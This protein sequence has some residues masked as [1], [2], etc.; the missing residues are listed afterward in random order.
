MSYGTIDDLCFYEVVGCPIILP[1]RSILGYVEGIKR[2]RGGCELWLLRTE[3][4]REIQ[5]PI[6]EQLIVE[7]NPY[8]SVLIDPP[9]YLLDMYREGRHPENICDI[10]EREVASYRKKAA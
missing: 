6:Y 5:F 3:D 8:E 4:G 7:C 9:E 10:V 2:H 1:D